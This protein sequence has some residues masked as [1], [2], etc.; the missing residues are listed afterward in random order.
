MVPIDPVTIA[1]IGLLLGI[2]A[3]TALPYLRK[4]RAERLEW[5]HRYTASAVATFILCL[6]AA[7]LVFPAFTVPEDFF[8]HVLLGAFAFGF[9]VDSAVIEG[10][11]W[12]FPKKTEL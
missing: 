11:E 2:C 9:G 8:L 5:S 6:I 3:R 7:A 12:V 10:S 1:F 4:A